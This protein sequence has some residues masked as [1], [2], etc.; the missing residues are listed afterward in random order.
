M[1]KKKVLFLLKLAISTGLIGYLLIKADIRALFNAAS[2][3]N[4]LF[5]LAA[6]L[7]S[8]LSILIRSYK[9][10]LLLNLQGARVSLGHIV[11][12]TYMSLFFSNFAPGAIGG[13]LFRIYKTR[14]Y[15]VLK[16]GSVSS[17]FVDRA[18]GF[19]TLFFVV[20]IFG[21]I[22]LFMINPLL[23]REQL[24]LIILYC[25]GFVVILILLYILLIRSS[26]VSFLS[27][28][29]AFER[30]LKDFKQSLDIHKNHKRIVFSCLILSFI[31]YLSCSL[32]M[33]LF[34]LSAS[35]NINFLRLAFV[36]PLIT[37][38]AMIPISFNGIGIQEGSYYFFFQKIG[39]NLESALLIAF[40]PRITMLVFSLLGGVLYLFQMKLKHPDELNIPKM[41]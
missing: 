36:V 40:L 27:K 12:I 5:F 16:S 9:W 11:A 8:I 21:A 14:N 26:K 32:V 10:Q 4:P 41:P 1:M 35:I 6:L 38:L 13:D 29:P 24:F 19:I 31:F 39:V 17:I 15:P 3:I 7:I 25:M 28:L 22:D 2:Q 33:Y 37:F 20:F 18:T 30:V 23:T 34:S